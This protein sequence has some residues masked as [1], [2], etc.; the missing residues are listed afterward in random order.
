MEL[1]TELILIGRVA[2]GTFLGFLIGFERELRGK[3]AGERT[4]GLLALG[5]AGVT[6]LGVLAFPASAEKVIAG[7]IT[8][9]GFLGA[10]LIFRERGA[11]QVLGLTTAASSWAAAAVGILAGAGAYLASIASCVIVLLL[12]EVNRLPVYRKL[13]P[14]KVRRDKAAGGYDPRAGT[15]SFPTE[16]EDLPPQDG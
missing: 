11:A 10:G 4:F 9:V 8:G 6:G 5:A 2:L 16:P 13:D 1:R 15:T 12:L 7:V 14:S 3:P